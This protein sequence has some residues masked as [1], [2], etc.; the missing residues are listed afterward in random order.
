MDLQQIRRDIEGELEDARFLA[1]MSL[2]TSSEPGVQEEV[3]RI[4]NQNDPILKLMFLRF[5]SH[6]PERKAVGYICRLME[7]DNVVV[8]EAARH[9]FEQNRY[10]ARLDILMPLIFSKIFYAQRFAIEFVGREGRMDAVEPLVTMAENANEALLLVILTTLRFLPSVSSIPITL[11]YINDQR[12][13][14][15]FRA[16]LLCGELMDVEMKQLRSSLLSLLQDPSSRV[17]RAALWGLRRHPEKSD[18]EILIVIATKD[19]DP[20]VRQEAILGLAEFPNDR[21]IQMLLNILVTEKDRWVSLKCESVLLGMP[22]RYLIKGLNDVL[23]HAKGD[24]RNKAI[25]LAADYQ[26][27]S[28][29]YLKFLLKGLVNVA[30]DKERIPYL[31]ALGIFGSPDAV[32]ILLMYVYGSPI[33]AY[34]AMTSLLKVHPSPDTYLT[35]LEK[36]NTSSLIKQIVL[37]YLA[38][39][40]LV[41]RTYRDRLVKCLM[42]FLRGDNINMRYLAAQVLIN[43]TGEEAQEA[44]L[45]TIEHETDPA[46][47]HLLRT[48][49]TEFFT[50]DPQGF[51]DLLSRRRDSEF[52]FGEMGLLLQD[53]IWSSNDI[54]AQL[55]SLLSPDFVKGNEVYLQNCVVWLADQILQGRVSLENVLKTIRGIPGVESVV[56]RLSKILVAH[57]DVRLTISADTCQRWLKTGDDASCAAIID[58]MGIAHDVSSIPVLV[59]VVCNDALQPFRQNAVEALG[60]LTGAVND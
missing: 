19:S 11:H 2:Y 50:K 47:L 6:V 57:P 35:Y 44:L 24:V 42:G 10:E 40:P 37:R 23:A 52:V 7:N 5:L 46:S 41:D 49:L 3:D 22:S 45:D 1:F 31:E 32:P 39:K 38:R 33:V 59:S 27:G 34:V 30:S 53:V 29:E 28:P 18:V 21:V 17:R 12:E 36:P 15:R 20:M 25:L 16:T 55:P 54:L 43:V 9:A 58:L 51:V 60:R 8:S 13:E 26:R 4:V 14:V 56:V 48:S